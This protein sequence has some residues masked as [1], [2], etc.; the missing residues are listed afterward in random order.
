MDLVIP[1]MSG[2]DVLTELRNDETLDSIPVVVVTSKDLSDEEKELLAA[3][4][5][6][7]MWQKG[8]IDRQKLVADV[9]AQLT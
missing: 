1:D 9:E 6:F 2:F 8:K 5:V 7:S 3:N 4:Q